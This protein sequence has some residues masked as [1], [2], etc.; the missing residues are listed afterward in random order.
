[1]HLTRFLPSPSIWLS[2]LALTATTLAVAAEPVRQTPFASHYSNS[3]L[4]DNRYVNSNIIGGSVS[5]SSGSVSSSGSISSSSAGNSSAISI[6]QAAGYSTQ[7]SVS[8]GRQGNGELGEAHRR[9]PPFNAIYLLIPA[10]L[11]Y[12]PAAFSQLTLTTDSNLLEIITTEV[13]GDTLIISASE[14]FSSRHP[15]HISSSSAALVA[16]TLQGSGELRIHDVEAETLQ[17]TVLGAGSI[18]ATGQVDT[19][20]AN[21]QGS[22]VIDTFALTAEGCQLSLQGS[23][24]LQSLCR[25]RLAANLLGSGSIRVDGSPLEKQLSR[26]GSGAIQVR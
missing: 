21:I 25:S 17:L 1:M 18:A 3:D 26:L 10:T 7:Q 14:G 24:A 4:V 6:Q 11:D 16:A 23:G 15:I 12:R 2:T 20:S 19:L 22:G 8:R 13:D 5:V 9:L